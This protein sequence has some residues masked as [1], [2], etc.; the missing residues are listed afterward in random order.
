MKQHFVYLAVVALLLVFIGFNRCGKED[1]KVETETKTVV[2]SSTVDSLQEQIEYLK[3]VPPETVSTTIEVPTEPETVVV[4]EDGTRVKEYRSTYKDSILSASW[5]TGLT[6]SLR[7]QD[8]SY[9]IHR[10]SVIEKTIT[11]VRTVYRTKE[12]TTTIT[13]QTGGFLAIGGD[14]GYSKVSPS[15]GSIQIRYQAKDGYSYHGRYD[16]FLDAYYIGGT[17]PIRTGINLPF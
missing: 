8:F 15:I 12:T 1:E 11:K 6:G 3:S 17:I 4:A 2:D 16:P 5:T 10:K 14:V 9:A 13:K 7:Y